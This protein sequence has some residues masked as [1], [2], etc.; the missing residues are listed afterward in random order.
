ML[1]KNYLHVGFLDYFHIILKLLDMALFKEI[2]LTDADRY[3]HDLKIVITNLLVG[4]LDDIHNYLT[5]TTDSTDNYQHYLKPACWFPGEQ[6]LVPVP[7]PPRCTLE[8][9][10]LWN[11][12]T[13]IHDTMIHVSHSTTNDTDGLFTFHVSRQ[14]SSSHQGLR[15]RVEAEK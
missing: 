14:I 9:V 5:L 4:F 3:P 15:S 13:L 1:S 10:I 11:H 12:D 8:I 7:Q 2:K 6:P